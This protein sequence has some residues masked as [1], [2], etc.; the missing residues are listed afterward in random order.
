MSR[1]ATVKHIEMTLPKAVPA[2]ITA[3]DSVEDCRKMIGGE[4]A[5]IF[6]HII[7]VLHESKDVIAFI[8]Q[9]FHSPAHS[10]TSV[11]IISDLV[12]K[13]EVMAEASSHDYDKLIDERR[14]RFIFKPLKPSKFAVIFDPQKEREISTDRNENSAAQV[15]VN[16]KMVF[17]DMKKRLGNK[18]HRVLLVEDNKIN[19]TVLLKLLGKTSINVETVLDGVECTDKVFSKD[20]GYYSI[21]LCDL[22][23]PNKDGYQTCKEIRKWEKKNKY[24]YLPI[25]ALSANVL[26]DVYSKCVEAGFNSYV[27]KPVDFK[28]LSAVM[29]RFLDPPEPSKP[30]EFM[31]PRKE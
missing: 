8:D 24:P 28:E 31:R 15:A 12:Q 16:Q 4:D 27:T 22:H 20:H 13:R 26:G 11:I 3:R 5:V 25:I 1:D 10:T 9:I 21:I 17:D 30:H 14:L 7:L 23:M 6:T 29:T 19:Q 2:Q 18:G